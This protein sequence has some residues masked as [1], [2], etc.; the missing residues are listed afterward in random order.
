MFD[1]I[2]GG[3]FCLFIVGLGLSALSL[4]S[5]VVVILVETPL[6]S[7]RQIEELSGVALGFMTGSVTCFLSALCSAAMFFVE[8]RSPAR[9]VADED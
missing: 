8:S 9:A 2:K 3:L 7:T 1:F 6:F 4:I 5:G